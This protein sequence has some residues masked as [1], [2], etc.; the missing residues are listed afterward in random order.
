M[1]DV[2]IS[3]VSRF[4]SFVLCFSVVH[5]KQCVADEASADTSG[6][7]GRASSATLTSKLIVSV[8]QYLW[9]S[10]EVL[11]PAAKRH[12]RVLNGQRLALGVG[13]ASRRTGSE[14]PVTRRCVSVRKQRIKTPA[15]RES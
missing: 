14:A 6:E 10:E 1:P 13:R 3:L 12:S 2:T 4:D 11:L 7:P 5:L 9:I 8:S 15:G